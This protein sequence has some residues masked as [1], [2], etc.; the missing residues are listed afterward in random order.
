MF[1]PFIRN[2]RKSEAVAAG[3][4]LNALSASGLKAQDFKWRER[5]GFDFNS[6]P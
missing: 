6:V 1:H 3:A 5:E 4:L 2:K